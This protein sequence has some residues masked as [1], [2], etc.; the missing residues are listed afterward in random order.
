MSKYILTIDQSTTGTKSVLFDRDGG[1]V[2]DES[3]TH[4]QYYPAPGWVEQDAEEIFDQTTQ[5]I[6]NV[7]KNSGVSPE[8]VLALAITVQTGA[9]VVWDKIPESLCIILLDGS[10]TGEKKSAPA[11]PTKK[12]KSF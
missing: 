11:Y 8:D 10:A 12:K 3:L 9:F 5:V 7:L 6:Q 4:R 1:I 2:A